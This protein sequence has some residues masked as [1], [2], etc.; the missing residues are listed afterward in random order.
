MCELK[1]VALGVPSTIVSSYLRLHCKA[2]V[3]REPILRLSTPPRLPVYTHPRPHFGLF[4]DL[5]REHPLCLSI[6]HSTL[7]VRGDLAN[8]IC[9]SIAKEGAHSF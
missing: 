5:R 7:Y 3:D 2:L 1:E 8:N 4:N 6:L 9:T